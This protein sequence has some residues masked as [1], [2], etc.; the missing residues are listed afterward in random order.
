M[1]LV[2]VEIAYQT[3]PEIRPHKR[4]VLIYRHCLRMG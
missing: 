3:G 2:K 4:N 1:Y